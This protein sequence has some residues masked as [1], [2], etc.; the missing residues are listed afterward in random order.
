MRGIYTPTGHNT[1]G[2]ISS[3]EFDFGIS[4]S[5]KL[6]FVITEGQDTQTD[7]PAKQLVKGPVLENQIVYKPDP[8][9]GG[10]VTFDNP[11]DAGNVI[12]FYLT[13]R[14]P[15]QPYNFDN[16]TKL[17]LEGIEDALDLIVGQIITL[18]NEAKRSIKYP[19]STTPSL[20]DGEIVIPT[21]EDGQIGVIG[22]FGVTVLEGDIGG[23]TETAVSIKDKLETLSGEDRL[24]ADA[25]K[26]L[27]ETTGDTAESIKD[28]LET[29]VL[30]DRLSA[31]AIKDLPET[32]GDTAESIKD[33]LETLVLEDRLDA[34]AIKNLPENTGGMSGAV[35]RIAD[36]IEFETGE[37]GLLIFNGVPK[38]FLA[39]SDFT[40]D[41]GVTTSQFKPV[42]TP[43]KLEVGTIVVKSQIVWIEESNQI[44]L[45]LAR[46]DQT[47]T[48]ATLPP[49][50]TYWQ[51]LH[52]STISKIPT[53]QLDT[54]EHADDVVLDPTKD[55]RLNFESISGTGVAVLI[56]GQPEEGAS[57]IP[58]QIEK[59]PSATIQG[60]D[61]SVLGRTE[62]KDIVWD[63]QPPN[64]ANTIDLPGVL[65]Y[66]AGGYLTSN[67]IIV[68]TFKS[69]T[70]AGIH[71][72]STMASIGTV[73]LNPNT[74][75]VVYNNKV[76][77]INSTGL[78]RVLNVNGTVDA[79]HPANG[80]Q[81]KLNLAVN[82]YLFKGVI[83]AFIPSGFT[84]GE[85]VRVDIS[86]DVASEE[87]WYESEE[88]DA[89]IEDEGNYF[90]RTD[91]MFVMSENNNFRF[92]IWEIIGDEIDWSDF[93]D[94]SVN[95]ALFN[96]IATPF[97]FGNERI[98]FP[99]ASS[100]GVQYL[101]AG[102]SDVLVGKSY[103]FEGVTDFV[104]RTIKDVPAI[105]NRQLPDTTEAE[106]LA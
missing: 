1:D 103:D 26:N 91:N 46:Q 81:T 31:D 105:L 28:K 78:L 104:E 77:E 79:D 83:Y 38:L 37:M 51:K 93:R 59:F 56:K 42:V 106:S 39:I 63:N 74:L 17:D 80:F 84:I 86:G 21:I 54:V 23:M 7:V 64:S 24:D 6:T 52:E 67:S 19:L 61:Q 75:F 99:R 70:T 30:E 35:K 58:A 36:G 95:S 55:N 57:S 71:D 49:N 48:S 33:K 44:V 87:T 32:T 11:P 27:P 40:S 85:L 2:I 9:E 98:Y 34:S 25:I 66:T 18:K 3:F 90:F 29:L 43:E 68:K 20:L 5:S 14:T 41:G 102:P 101:N 47:V 22:T 100:P 45:Y 15:E 8:D 65:S 94:L 96:N 89:H 16:K 12:T 53:V 97:F 10:T 76:I 50:S 82:P 13:D 4:K 72:L 62:S 69:S 88:Y 92:R 73:I 60:D